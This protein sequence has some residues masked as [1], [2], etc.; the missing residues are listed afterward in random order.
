VL[1]MNPKDASILD[2][3]DGEMVRVIS[4]RGAITARAKVTEVTPAEVVTMNFHF[5]ETPTNQ[6][7]ISAVDPVAKIPEYKVCAVRV[8]KV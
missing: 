4:R 6:L 3:G 7:T 5:A 1:E 2:L 8:E